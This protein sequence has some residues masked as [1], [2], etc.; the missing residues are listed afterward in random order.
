MRV[1]IISDVHANLEA[2][3]AV[4]KE[5][6]RVGVD[7]IVSLGDVV[8]YN[9]N[10]NEC[11]DLL[12]ERTI[13]SL[14]GNH[15]AVAAGLEDPIDFN[16][17]ARKAVVW[18]RTVLNDEH[19]QYLREQPERR[20]LAPGIELVHGSLLN[21][22]HY[23]LSDWDVEQNFSLMSAANPP[24]HVLFFG[25]THCQEAFTMRPDGVWSTVAERVLYLKEGECALVN[26]G[27]VGQPR[28]QDPRAA[29]A[30]YDSDAQK[31]ELFRTA[32]DVATCAQKIL[33]AG[34][35]K[36]L[37]HRLYQGW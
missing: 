22:D 26:P 27:S 13:P 9:P 21:R 1:A 10:P 31:I 37:A 4:L 24:I 12:M 17:I 30:I 15:D 32:Y 18:T 36:E 14:M 20:R 2:F 3:E 8:G 16:P 29:F 28:D 25:H 35:P 7:S 6:D 23:I 5:I 33:A 11:I 34:L 19:K